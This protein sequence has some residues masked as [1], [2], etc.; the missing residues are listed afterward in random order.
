[1]GQEVWHQVSKYGAIF[2]GHMLGGENGF[3]GGNVR[4][5][6]NTATG[7]IQAYSEDN[8]MQKTTHNLPSW[9]ARSYGGLRPETQPP[10]L[11]QVNIFAGPNQTPSAM[12]NES[13]WLVNNSGAAASIAAAE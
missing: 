5:L 3:L 13:M 2:A 4:M 8:P 10:R 6:L 12:M 1:L 11:A 7:E 9:M